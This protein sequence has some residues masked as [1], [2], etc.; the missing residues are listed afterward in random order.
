MRRAL[1]G[2]NGYGLDANGSEESVRGLAG[3]RTFRV[4]YAK[5]VAPDNCVL[6]IFGDARTTELKTALE[7]PLHAAG[8][9]PR[10]R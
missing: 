5:M 9:L 1:F 6:A 2:C 8:K 7:K 10:R 4:F 3:L